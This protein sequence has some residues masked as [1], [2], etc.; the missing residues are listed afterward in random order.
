MTQLIKIFVIQEV[1]EI[2]RPFLITFGI[3]LA[4]GFIFLIFCI[5]YKVITILK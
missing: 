4:L 1:I 2:L 3:L 5:V